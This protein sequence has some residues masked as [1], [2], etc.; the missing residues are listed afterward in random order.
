MPMLR[1]ILLSLSLLT[2]Y[3]QASTPHAWSDQRQ[4]ML[5][6]CL[7]ASQLKDAHALGKP[8]EFDDQVGYS[9]LLLEGTYPQKH[10][11]NRTGTELCLYDRQRQQAFTTEWEAGKR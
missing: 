9:A 4:H 1:S 11:Q 5:K 7:G 6:A 2:V 3:A 10:M 8:A